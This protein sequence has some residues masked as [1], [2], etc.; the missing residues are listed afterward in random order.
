MSLTRNLSSS[1]LAGV[2]GGF[3]TAAALVGSYTSLLLLKSVDHEENNELKDAIE[4]KTAAISFTINLSVSLGT[5]AQGLTNALRASKEA[6]PKEKL[7]MA[8]CLIGSVAALVTEVVYYTTEDNVETKTFNSGLGAS[9]SA[10]LSTFAN[11]I[12]HYSQLRANLP[13]EP[14]KKQLLSETIRGAVSVGTVVGVGQ[15]SDQL[16]ALIHQIES[17]ELTAEASLAGARISSRFNAI[18]TAS[19]FIQFI[20]DALIAGDKLNAKDI[21]ALAVCL[22]LSGTSTYFALAEHHNPTPDMALVKA[23][24]TAASLSFFTIGQLISQNAAARRPEPELE[25]ESRQRLLA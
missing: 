21:S 23:G 25:P 20:K 13:A 5:L 15:M 24:L 1:L 9:T 3:S 18:A 4:D 11:S 14:L 6:T 10:I 17:P 22:G 19:M 7:A 8:A 12:A 2:R 16:L